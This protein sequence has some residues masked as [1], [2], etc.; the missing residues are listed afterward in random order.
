MENE[1]YIIFVEVKVV[2][3]LDNLHDYITSKKL[4]TLK[5]SI[6]TYLWKYPTSKIVRIDIVFIKDQKVVEIF[7]NIEI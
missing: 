2:N 3:Y 6:E 7:K 5:H 1:V 4:Q